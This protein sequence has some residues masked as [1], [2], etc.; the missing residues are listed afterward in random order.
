[1]NNRIVMLKLL[2]S[3]LI[4]LLLTAYLET[5]VLGSEWVVRDAEI[6]GTTIHTEVWHSN[7]Q[8]AQDAAELVLQTMR[9]VNASMSPYIDTS[10]LSSVNKNA[11][12]QVLPISDEL[13]QVIARSLHYSD[14]TQGAFDITFASVGYLY[15]Y[16]NG[17][18][19]SE[20]EIQ[21]QLEGINF[22]HIEL[23][24]SSTEKSIRFKH[25]Q[26]CIDL[27]GIAKGYAVDLAI[28]RAQALGIEQI[29]VSAGGDSRIVGD[30]HGR[31]WVIGIRHP[32][33]KEKV[34]VKL[35]LVNEALS[36]SGD[37]ERYFDEDGVRYHHIIDPKTGD[38]AREVRSVTILGSNAMDTDALSTSVF[39]LGAEN[40]LALI[41]S[42]EG[43]EGIIVDR[44]ANLLF[45]SGLQNVD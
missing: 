39:V 4:Y 44:D 34:I 40:G 22:K 38:S 21:Q 45:S 36:T 31:P 29:I 12:S 41:E 35:P 19:P 26:V 9:E 43:I 10:E 18:R 11:A 8:L 23:N 6:M 32:I 1:M 2:V 13:Y 15:D 17:V 5:P 25:P 3:T 27:G 28:Q 42:L 16:R 37:Y 14:I 30:R 24:D 7:E 20:S 33:N